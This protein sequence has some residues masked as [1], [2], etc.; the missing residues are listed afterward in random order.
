MN[1]WLCAALGSRSARAV[2]GRS[3]SGC[4]CSDA[5]VALQFATGYFRARPRARRGRASSSI[6]SRHRAH[7][8]AARLSGEPALRAFSGALVMSARGNRRAGFA[9]ARGSS[10]SGFAASACSRCAIRSTGCMPSAR[11]TFCRRLLVAA[12]VLV[13]S[14]F[15]QVGDQDDPDRADFI[16][17]SA[18]RH[19]RDRARGATVAKRATSQAKNERAPAR[20][21]PAR[22]GRRHAAPSSRAIR[23]GR[24]WSSVSTD[25]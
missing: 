16:L 15:S 13:Q 4:R 22:G 21:F 23:C 7:A 20:H 1:I 17:T 19:A 25:R 3:C 12:A 8:R 11:R 24:R 9:R 2:R 18:D 5:L 14:G 6:V 10:S